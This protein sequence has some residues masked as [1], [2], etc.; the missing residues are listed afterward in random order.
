MALVGLLLC[1]LSLLIS[2]TPAAHASSKFDFRANG[3][4]EPRSYYYNGATGY[5]TLLDR[6]RAN[7]RAT[8]ATSN[9]L[10]GEREFRARGGVVKRYLTTAWIWFENGSAYW[11]DPYLIN[12]RNSSAD[13]QVSLLCGSSNFQIAGYQAYTRRYDYVRM[14]RKFYGDSQLR[15]VM[16]RVV[17]NSYRASRSAWSYTYSGQQKGLVATYRPR[18]GTATIGDI[19]PNSGFF[20]NRGQFFTLIVGKDPYVAIALNSYAVSDGDL[21]RAL[22]NYSC[23]YG[24]ICAR[25][26]QLLSNMV[27]ALI[28]YET[29]SL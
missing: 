17:D 10:R 24:Y 2:P 27:A 22:K 9:L 16:Q 3:L 21:V 4:P 5:S 23:A 28:I 13:S 20:T 7:S 12:C 25:E 1:T 29:G 19:S 18:I 14:Y 15:T 26:K 6:I 8:W 11:P